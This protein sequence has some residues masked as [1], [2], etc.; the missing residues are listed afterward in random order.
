MKKA[1]F[2]GLMCILAT[3]WAAQAATYGVFVG[4]NEYNTSY[5]PSDNWLS[6]C[7]PDANHIYTNTLKRGAWTTGTVT[8]LLNSA[9]T[10]AAVRQAISNRA[11]SAVSGDVGLEKVGGVGP[12][13]S[14]RRR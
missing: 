5:V 11:V 13:G 4:L 1:M 12:A 6:G 7:V 10:K 8:R 2:L 9:G 3:G 14:W